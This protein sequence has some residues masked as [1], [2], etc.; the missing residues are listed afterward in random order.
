VNGCCLLGDGPLSDDTPV[1]SP[2]AQG[3]VIA[4]RA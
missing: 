4:E 2:D 1:L 3:M